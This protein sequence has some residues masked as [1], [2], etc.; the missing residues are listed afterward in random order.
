MELFDIIELESQAATTAGGGPQG[1]GATTFAIHQ[2]W[3]AATMNAFAPCDLLLV[4]MDSIQFHVHQGRL[5]AASTNSFNGKLPLPLIRSDDHGTGGHGL[6]VLNVPYIGVVLNITLYIMYNRV[7]RIENPNPLLSDLSS[8]VLALK[9]FGAPLEASLSESSLLFGLFSSMCDSGSPLDVY[10]TAASH[11]PD[12]HHVAV[13]ASQF[14]LTLDL[15]SI[16]DDVADKM[17]AVYLRRLFMLHVGRVMEFKKL[18][19]GPPE[20]HAPTSQCNADTLLQ[21]WALAT[22]YLTWAASPSVT[23][24]AIDNVMASIVDRLGCRRCEVALRERFDLM[25]QT[26]SLVKATI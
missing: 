1:A 24:S 26:W 20:T 16:T 13:Y 18:I 6:P 15:Y 21:V 25:K 3:S 9:E 5:G 14:L 8:T 23:N 12:L 4:S 19:T 2:D 11:A 10:A 17:G 22:A 7:G